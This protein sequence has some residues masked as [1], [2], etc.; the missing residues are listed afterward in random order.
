MSDSVR[1]LTSLLDV[2]QA[3]LLALNIL[4]GKDCLWS[5][6]ISAILNDLT[7][8]CDYNWSEILIGAVIF[9]HLS[10]SKAD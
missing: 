8:S 1:W 6:T 7:P 2:W 4:A 3:E 10:N 5:V 9:S